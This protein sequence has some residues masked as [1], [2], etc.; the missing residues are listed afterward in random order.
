MTAP[1]QVLSLMKIAAELRASGLSWETVAVKVK[2]TPRACRGWPERY[3]QDWD[4]LYRAA[5]TK[6][7]HEA[8]G[9][10]LSY[11]RKFLRSEDAWLGQNTAKFL[12]A[13]GEA[14]RARESQEGTA[15][16]RLGEWA[17]YISQLETMSDAAVK[18]FLVEFV[19][20]RLAQAGAAV[21]AADGGASPAEPE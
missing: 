15:A 7:R 5:E 19:A 13:H 2:R 10:A 18:A 21:P 9:E 16:E 8:R 6:L 17:P 11:L 1:P 12:Y 3:P 20:R 14:D 4:R